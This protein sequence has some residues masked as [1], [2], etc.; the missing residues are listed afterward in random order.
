MTLLFSEG[1]GAYAAQADLA[2]YGISSVGS[3]VYAANGGYNNAPCFQFSTGG[4]YTANYMDFTNPFAAPASNE[5]RFAFWFK[6]AS[7][8]MH[9]LGESR[10][11]VSISNLT[12]T[13]AIDVRLT[14]TGQIAIHALNPTANLFS[15]G[16]YYVGSGSYN[17]GQPHFVEVRAVVAG[18]LGGT[19]Q[20]W[21]DG[22][23][24]INQVGISNDGGLGL[25]A[26]DLRRVW[27][28]LWTTNVVAFTSHVMVWDTSGTGMTGYIGPSTI[29]TL[30]PNAVGDLSG[31]SPSSGANYTTVNEAVANFDTNYVEAATSGLS[32]LYNYTTLS[33]TPAAIRGVMVK[34][35]AKN[36]DVGAK[37][38]RNICKSGTV[39]ALGADQNLTVAYK[40]Y[41]EFF[42]VDP[43]TA[44][45]WTKAAIDAFQP[46]VEART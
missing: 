39:T 8:S 13:N 34:S 4:V 10:S 29:V 15:T 17:D 42:G 27:L 32:D 6:A 43:N 1:F 12:G 33:T 9:A 28:S 23:Q 11:S 36:A 24:E 40:Q 35:F 3:L 14:G 44:A 45:A 19:F 37:A 20:V 2:N 41:V 46:G 26:T 18:S 7:G 21:V 22:T 38:F 31:L 16:N 25:T 30:W 5:I